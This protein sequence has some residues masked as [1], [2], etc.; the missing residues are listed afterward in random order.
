MEYLT[1][2]IALILLAVSLL[3]GFVDA[4][5]GGG[6]LLALPALLWAGLPPA[7][8]LGTNKLQGSFGTLAASLS[9]WRKGLIRPR[10]IWPAIVCT[11]MGAVAGTW[12]VQSLPGRVL[13]D[14]LPVLLIGFAIYFLFSPRLGDRDAKA[15]IGA[16]GFALLI[17]TGVGFYDGFFGPGTGSFF[18]MAYVALLGLN[19]TRATAQTK[20]LNLTS[21]LAS[22]LAF[23]LGGSVVWSVGLL[24][25]CGQFAGAWLGAHL[26][27]RHGARLIRPLLV[28]VSI[29]MSLKLLLG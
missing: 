3:A 23:S 19:L 29:G 4:I 7:L 2:E 6:G 10:E 12:L 9:F 28:A 5:A 18:V 22:L 16:F 11:F 17:G 13:E 15:R 27:H 25:A 14:L 21:N 24:M 26:A 8:A 1:P 20:A